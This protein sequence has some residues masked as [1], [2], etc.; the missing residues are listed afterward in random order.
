MGSNEQLS[1]RTTI[2]FNRDQE[3]HRNT[4]CE[5]HPESPAR[6]DLCVSVLRESG[7]LDECQ[8][9][10]EFPELD[11]IDLRQSHS[12]EHVNRLLK[13]SVSMN[14][15]SLNRLCEHY[16]SVFMSPGTIKAAKTAVSCCR[17]LAESIVEDKIPN[18]F[19]LVRPPGHHAGRSSACGFCIF[20]NSAQAA[21]AAFNFGADRILIVDLDVHHGNGTQEIFY[22]DKRVLYFSIHRYEAGKYWPHLRESNFDHIGEFEGKGYNVN[23]PLNDIGCGDADYMA[24][25]WNVLY[26]VASQFNPDLVVVSAGFDCCTGDPLGDM[27][28]SPD[29]YSHM[30]YHI[31]ALARG[32]VLIV[33]EGGYNHSVTAM[34]VQRCVRVLRGYKPFPLDVMECPKRSTVE[35]CLNCISALKPFWTCFD[36]YNINGPFMD[37]EWDIHRPLIAFEPPSKDEVEN[38]G[39]VHQADLVQLRRNCEASSAATKTLLIHNGDTEQHHS[40]VESDHPEKPERTVRI[41]DEL[42]RTGVLSK[43]VVVESERSVTEK[44][45]ESV[46]ERPF[47]RRMKDTVGMTE[48]ELRVFEDGL[49]SIF[50]CNSSFEIAE[51]A[52]LREITGFV[53]HNPEQ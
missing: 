32:K 8:Q 20:N 10:E 5:D 15:N 52:Q 31:S 47:I 50:L 13:D 43:C 25:F 48:K 3:L 2:G 46:H 19:A 29:A 33:L 6:I 41:M 38:T 26:P 17:F 7:L 9:V 37:V 36:F 39:A 53:I 44:E 12:E 4:L 40:S 27:R 23:V 22:E 42:E 51:L 34:C 30:V 18:A 14:Q 1:Y 21:E 28:L 24:I 35:S 45:L 11:E 49:N 16:D